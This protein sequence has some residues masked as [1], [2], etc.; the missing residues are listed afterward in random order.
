MSFA[1][2]L[3][4]KVENVELPKPGQWIRQGQKVLSFYRGGE[5]TEMVFTYRR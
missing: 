4:G 3:A 1:A 2:A 5:K